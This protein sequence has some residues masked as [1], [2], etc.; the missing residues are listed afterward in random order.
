MKTFLNTSGSVF[1]LRKNQVALYQGIPPLKTVLAEALQSD[2]KVQVRIQKVDEGFHFEVVLDYDPI[3]TDT[4]W[5]VSS[6]ILSIAAIPEDPTFGL[7]WELA[8]KW[9]KSKGLPEAEGTLF[10]QCE[11][12]HLRSYK[13]ERVSLPLLLLLTL[14]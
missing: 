9:A 11:D 2:I 6:F 8:N 1:P 5:N 4:L 3:D 7:K 10:R 14:L 13:V 12:S